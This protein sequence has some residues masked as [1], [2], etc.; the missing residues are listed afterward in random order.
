VF[1]KD[2]LEALATL[3]EAGKSE[4]SS[5]S[6]EPAAFEAHVA[7]HVSS[8]GTAAAEIGALRA[9]D[10][11]LA[12]ACARGDERAVA[13]FRERYGADVDRALA[14]VRVA[15]METQ[16]LSQE[17]ARRML[18]PPDPKIADYSGR[19][20][21]RAWVRVV[22]TRFALDLARLK[23]NNAERPTDESSF[24]SLPAASDSPELAVFR[25]LYQQE[26]KL[27]IEEAARSLGVEERNALREHYV[28]GLTVDQIAEVHGIH[29]AT[30]ARRVQRARDVLIASVK[31]T[32]TARHGL[33][34]RDLVS[35]MGLVRSQL[36][37]TMDRVLG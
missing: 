16:D 29:R 7:R 37:V 6:I 28:R 5:L 18:V 31:A 22:A 17:L 26:V 1:G 12:C 13:I 21:L 27:A 8:A 19:G 23:K 33:A 2:A 20:D 35:I 15:S 24:A 14:R 25:R 30:A 3:F 36:H 9:G 10:L 4:H 34:G 32:L 11:F